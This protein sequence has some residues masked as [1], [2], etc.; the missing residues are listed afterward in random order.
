MRIDS[1]VLHN[2]R[3]YLCLKL[4]FD[5]HFNLF[6][7][8][9]GQGK[10]NLI[11]GINFLATGKSL[12]TR[13]EEEL[14]LWGKDNCSVSAKVGYSHRESSLQISLH[15]ADRKK[16]YSVNGLMQKKRDF[17]G[18]LT[19]VIFTPDDL[20]IVKGA[21]GIRRKFIDDEISKV[22]PVYEN[23]INRYQHVLRQRNYLLKTHR[24]K[25]LG[26]DELI[27]WNEQLALLGAKIVSKR[28]SVIRR[29]SLLSRLA[30]RRLTKRTESL[31][32]N[33]HSSFMAQDQDYTDLP[34]LTELFLNNL[35]EKKEQEACLGQTLTGP[36]RDDFYFILNGRDARFFASQGQQRT[37]VLSLKIA[38]LE[39][40]KGETGEFPVLLFDDVFSEL[41]EDRRNAL[42]DVLDSRIQI[43]ISGTEADKLGKIKASG[44]LFQVVGGEVK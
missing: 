20:A 11:E 19:T 12:R 39:F 28:F 8:A 13:N 29:L 32:I 25:I 16:T 36:H 2:F 34:L 18:K 43:F 41:D 4:S 17:T 23:E 38:E 21:P 22:S 1:L 24:K 5:N 10:T 3:N 6:I 14:I 7:G 33:Y 42:L 37:L 35:S 40:I 31:D 15:A 30:Q 27:G 26:S 44:K 9:N